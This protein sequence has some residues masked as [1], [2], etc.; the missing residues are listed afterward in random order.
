MMFMRSPLI[1]R[2][3]EFFSRYWKEQDYVADWPGFTPNRIYGNIMK[4]VDEIWPYINFIVAVVNVMSWTDPLNSLAW[5]CT[6]IFLAL[7]PQYMFS[8]LQSCLIVHIMYRY[9]DRKAKAHHESIEEA[10]KGKLKKGE[11]EDEMAD[12]AKQAET[13]QKAEEQRRKEEEEQIANLGFFVN[14]LGR[15]FARMDATTNVQNYLG[16][17]AGILKTIRNLFDWESPTVTLVILIILLASTAMH[18]FTSFRWGG[19]GEGSNPSAGFT[20]I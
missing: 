3:G 6:L 17:V 18:L 10:A 5:L 20:S 19:G 15:T 1:G 11:T 16:M 12:E 2:Y 8:F 4:L 7:R 14:F 13:A 9:V